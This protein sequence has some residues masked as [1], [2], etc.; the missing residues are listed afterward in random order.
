[1]RIINRIYGWERPGGVKRVIKDDNPKN[2]T[3]K[4]FLHSQYCRVFPPTDNY[5]NSIIQ[6]RKGRIWIGSYQSGLYQFNAENEEF[7]QF[8][9][10]VIDSLQ[11]V[12]DLKLLSV[13]GST[14]ILVE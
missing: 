13:Y 5:V 10:K 2:I 8:I 11:F 6:D 1:L 9:P 14:A 3:F 4:S 12:K 7:R